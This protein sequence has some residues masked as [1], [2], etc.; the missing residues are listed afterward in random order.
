[1]LLEW[2]NTHLC[3]GTLVGDKYVVTAAHCI[4]KRW[5]RKVAIGLTTF[6]ARQKAKYF[7]LNINKTVIHPNYTRSPNE[8]DFAV[9]ELEEAVDLRAYP[10][11][12]PVC[13]PY[14]SLV[15]DFVG[16]I[17]VATGWGYLAYETKQRPDHLQEVK[18]KVQE[19]DTCGRLTQQI[20][21]R[22]AFSN[23]FCAGY[24]EG[25]K[26]TCHGDSGGPLV[27]SDPNN[28]K[29]LTLIGVTSWGHYCGKKD[30]PGVYADIPHVMQNHWL[31]DQLS[32]LKTCPPF[33]LND[34]QKTT[35]TT[36]TTTSINF[37]DGC[38]GANFKEGV[39][40]CWY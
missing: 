29:S 9:L 4:I 18:L 2:G 33:G 27:I 11:I 12:K 39:L 38:L 17:A 37:P 36:T 23:Q 20:D 40:D 34:E 25:E 21:R 26:D 3:G 31:L 22:N 16:K 5:S 6:S 24:L 14:E 28:N 30:Y 35:T 13:L 8:N 7:I 32:N 1:M 15:N 10:H 19:T